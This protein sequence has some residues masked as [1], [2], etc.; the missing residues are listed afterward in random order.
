MTTLDADECL[1]YSDDCRGRVEY[2]SIDPGRTG[3]VPRCEFH[4]GKRLDSRE[5]SVERYEFSDVPPPWLDESYAG[6]RWD[7]DY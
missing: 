6:E 1:D 3:A 7:N 5:D 4:W 2:H